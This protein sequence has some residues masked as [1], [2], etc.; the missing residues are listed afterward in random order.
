MRASAAARK[1]GLGI[2]EAAFKKRPG[3]I[4]YNNPPQRQPSKNK[5]VFCTKL[6]LTP[7]VIASFPK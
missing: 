3:R 5:V 2:W 6:L 4:C 1:K 7:L